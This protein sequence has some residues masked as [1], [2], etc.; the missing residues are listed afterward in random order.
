M[1]ESN[2]MTEKALKDFIKFKEDFSHYATNCL[3]IQTMEGTLAPF[4]FNICQ[5]LILKI[6][7]DIRDNNRLV[8][9]VILKA[10]REGIS[11]FTTGRFYHKTSM[12]HNRYA[13]CVTHEPDSTDFLFKMIKRYHL[14]VPSLLK[15]QTLY[16]NQKLL[17]FNTKD[18]DGLDSA[19]RVGTAV[20][21]DFGSGQLIHYAHFSEVAKWPKAQQEPLLTSIMQTIPDTA[22][23]EV[24]LESTAKGIGGE[25]HKR[26]W[27]SRYQYQIYL[28]EDGNPT[29]KCDINEKASKSNEFSSIFIPWFV[30]EKYYRPVPEGFKRTE[31][32]EKMVKL[33]NLNDKRLAWRRWAIENRCGGSEDAFKQE[34]PSNPEEAF[35][36]S[37]TPVFD[38][39]KVLEYQKR[40]P[41]PMARYEVRA[42]TGQFMTAPEGELR[43]WEEPR[44]G[45]CYVVGGDVAEGIPGKAD[46]SCLDVIDQL[47]GEQVAQWHGKCDP[48]ELG[49]I[50]F[51]LGVR[52][53]NAWVAIE[54]NNHGYTTLTTMKNLKYPRIYMEI[55]HD[56]SDKPRRRLG[57]VTNGATRPALIDTLIEEIRED[58][59]GIKC[60]ETFDEMLSFKKQEDGKMEAD[61]G[62]HDDRVISMGIAKR[63]RRG[64]P[65]PSQRLQAPEG[66]FTHRNGNHASRSVS[67]KAWT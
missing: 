42:F 1:S 22:D 45:K 12:E 66:H 27:G 35:L 28:D 44:Q 24:V 31:E 25:F 40:A 56:G 9:V 8:R 21:D 54:R 19:I 51:Y 47:S 14:H 30:F 46:F 15:P 59:H 13:V 49:K 6:F 7:K 23:T 16:S 17:E 43:V 67:P 11:T 34:Y 41:K 4:T 37:G 29:F 64:L 61:T 50:A 26:Y 60:E 18:G 38:N 58:S 3:K 63:V 55:A 5:Q 36:V 2:A 48:D 33:Y 39:N 52:Y 53:N 65:L 57:W 62:M 10:R 32:E 20:K